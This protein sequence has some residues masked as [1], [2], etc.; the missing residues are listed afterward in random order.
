VAVR[1]GRSKNAGRIVI[2]YYSLE[3]FDRISGTLGV[4]PE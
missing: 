1:P 4:R 3:D 2:D